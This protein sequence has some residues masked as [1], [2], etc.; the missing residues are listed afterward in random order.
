MTDSASRWFAQRLLRRTLA[1]AG[2]LVG[3]HF[4]LAWLMRHA[5]L[6]LGVVR[7][8]TK[9]YRLVPLYCEID[10]PGRLNFGLPAV[11]VVLA[12]FWRWFASAAWN[13]RRLRRGFV[14]AAMAWYVGLACLVAMIDGGP[15][16]LWRPYKNLH[17]TDYI[18]AVDRVESVR[19]YLRDFTALQ[20]TLPLHCRTHPPGGTLFLWAIDRHVWPGDRAAALATILVAALAVP[21]VHG[22]A[23]EVCSRR[24][25]RLATV[26]FIL[27]PNVLLF[28]A[29]SMEAV[30]MVPM[31]W[32]FY[33]LFRARRRRPVVLGVAGG[34]AASVAALMT[35]S[36]AWLAI[37]AVV[38]AVITAVFDRRRLR[39]TLVALASAAAASLV[40]YGLLWGWS[41]YNLVS[42]LTTAVGQHARI[43]EGG[44]QATFGQYVHLTVANPVAFFTGTGLVLA[45]LWAARTWKDARSGLFFLATRGGLLNLSFLGALAIVVVAPLYTLEVER[46]WIFLVPLVAIAAARELQE[47]EGRASRSSDLGNSQN[48]GETPVASDEA[49]PGPAIRMAF[50]LLAGQ[51]VLMEVVLN[52]LW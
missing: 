10:L 40:F 50:V 39:A 17:N 13:P 48:M 28:T 20:P 36:A 4:L 34:I 44:N 3:Y 8:G 12:G 14:P 18:G 9:V 30:F 41:G 33:L 19:G 45:V 22:L 37:W 31:V 24:T 46:I 25:A 27:A 49:R 32:T 35:F 29:T 16:R 43:M 2:A 38:L 21:A 5:G 51:S 52:T 47:C 6:V 15:S 23:R 42:V 26:L 1:L 11:V 7:P